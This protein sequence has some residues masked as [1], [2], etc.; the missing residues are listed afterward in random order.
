MTGGRWPAWLQGYDRRSGVDDLT[1]GLLVAMML[2]PQS[3]AYAMLAGLPV[4]AGL[5]AS[6][7]PLLA[8]AML[9]SSR[10]LAIG[11]AAIIALLTAA[12]LKQ[13]G[14]DHDVSPM[15]AAIWL[16]LL[17][18]LFQLLFGLLRLGV[19]TNLLS[20]AVINGFVAAAAVVIACSQL[21]HLLGTEVSGASLL[22][23]LADLLAGL[24]QV[25]GL[26][27][28]V[29]VGAML[30][31]LALRRWLSPA[32]QA[33]G[34]G[35]RPAAYLV[36]FAPLMLLALGLLAATMLQLP[37]RGVAVLGSVPAG[38]PPV[39]W[40]PM[41]PALVSSLVPSALLI[42]VLGFAESASIAQSLAMRRRER[43]RP[44]RELLGLGAANVAAGFSGG[45][46]VTG[47]LTRS[48][49][50]FDAGAATPLAGVVT[51]FIMLVTALLLAPLLGPLPRAVL[52]AIIIVTVLAQLDLRSLKRTWQHSRPDFAA[53]V[54]TVAGV[55]VIGV[56]TGLLLG[57]VTS[58]VLY[59]WR[60]S[61]PNVV[62]VGRI[63]GTEQF[64]NV[65]RHK[66]ETEPTVLTVR[67]D[68][69]LFFA[70]ARYLEDRILALVADC[71][72]VEDLV[73]Q[74]SGVN[75]IDGSALDVLDSIN[76][77]LH[78]A[79]VR[80]H[81]SEVKGPVMDVL[82]RADI[83]GHLSG[84]IF[85]TQ[86]EAFRELS[87]RR[88]SRDQSGENSGSPSEGR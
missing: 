50:S 25:H 26:T 71:P 80:F 53:L 86:Y 19:L 70:N 81:L 43:I 63:P 87:G 4:Q 76:L 10:V 30:L 34:L 65:A 6:I 24:E 2:L 45:M 83:S 64:R 74:C 11:P 13:A 58:V 44:D 78:L 36:R 46:P 68:E 49:I 42:A 47:S 5:Y 15:T 77:R 35:A 59:L 9:G 56:E 84:R 41:D 55:F 62:V 60:S 17:V 39:Q 66:V 85:F 32:L 21:G 29:G 54:V 52:A 38:L 22:Q 8:Y 40:P 75:S 37:E 82:N 28:L 61:R 14:A 48:V 73:L 18:G 20:H 7:M 1:A 23:L 31:L 16:A 3:L 12:A 27:L 79:G 72:D 67:V 57:L 69:S 88:R 33:A 51:A